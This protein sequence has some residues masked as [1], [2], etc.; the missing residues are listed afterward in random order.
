MSQDKMAKP[1][2]PETIRRG[3]YILEMMSE[4]PITHSQ[5]H[6]R[7][8]N[9]YGIEVSIRSIER[10]MWT[11]TD[12]FPRRIEVDDSKASY[13]YRL[14]QNHRKYSNM[15]P[16]EAV[17]LEL[18]FD[19]LFPLLP[20]K[21]MDPVMPY[22][23]EAEEILK[24]NSATKMK[25]WKSKVLTLNEGL[26]LMPA[27]V[28]D[29]VLENIH[30]ALWDGATVLASYM[31]KGKSWPSEYEL[32]PAGL[33][34][35]GRISYLVC[36]F[37]NDTKK[38]I[39]LPLQRFQ[40][41]KLLDGISVHKNKKIKNLAK[42]IMGFRLNPNKINVELK[43][44]KMAG[45]HLI[46]TP[47]SDDQKIT[48]TKDGFLKV[49]ASVTDD[50]ELRFWIRGFGDSVEVLKPKKLRD[51]FKQISRRMVRLYEQN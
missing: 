21:S 3:F 8:I 49:K 44:S 32:H 36:S 20:N 7:L 12:A 26:Q 6:T 5:I 29:G 2:A 18:A 35:R 15:S 47:L 50:M 4:R 38:I 37:A 30:A 34:Y 40:W 43:F 1:S 9:N 28:N 23:R 31:S 45:S 46:E 17:C 41:V 10:Q 11:L 13:E 42:D 24:Q 33:V 48:P 16:I 51:E 22:L 39:Y 25:N 14:P 27:K 19:Y